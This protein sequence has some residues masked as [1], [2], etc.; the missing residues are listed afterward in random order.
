MDAQ[1]ASTSLSSPLSPPSSSSALQD[2]PPFCSD[3]TAAETSQ[4]ETSQMETSPMELLRVSEA[5]LA[6]SAQFESQ[7]SFVT[8]PD[9]GSAV[10]VSSA[11]PCPASSRLRRQ[12]ADDD[13]EWGSVSADED[14]ASSLA[15]PVSAHQVK[16]KKGRLFQVRTWPKNIILNGVAAVGLRSSSRVNS[17]EEESCGTN[18]SHDTT[19]STLQA[20]KLRWKLSQQTSC[21]SSSTLL[22]NAT[23]TNVTLRSLDSAQRYL[24][25]PGGGSGSVEREEYEGLADADSLHDFE[26]DRPDRKFCQTSTPLHRARQ[27][28]YATI[29]EE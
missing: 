17:G 22:A 6:G 26:D 25:T 1:P 13:A 19:Q 18:A 21:G 23:N 12:E 11:V 27:K 14:A 10:S 7:T 28:P 4:T 29:L 8:A 3:D 20:R 5:G 2:P 9:D 24:L 16:S 15:G